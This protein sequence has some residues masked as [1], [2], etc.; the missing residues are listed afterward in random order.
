MPSSSSTSS[1]SPSCQHVDLLLLDLVIVDLLLLDLVDLLLLLS[2]SS[3]S[4]SSPC[5]RMCS[6]VCT[7]VICV[8]ISLL[9]L[10]DSHCRTVFIFWTLW[11]SLCAHLWYVG[12]VYG[13]CGI[14]LSGY[15]T[16]VLQGSLCLPLRLLLRVLVCL[17]ALSTWCLCVCVCVCVCVC[18]VVSIFIP[19]SWASLLVL[20]VRFARTRLYH[21][22]RLPL[23][24]PMVARRGR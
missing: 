10:C 23:S 1:S 7:V 22:L 16:V 19:N 14:T 20:C 18:T 9:V 4:T 21:L 17:C 11:T 12:I 24:S 5:V 15:S 6:C 3:S 13:R 2:S 8:L